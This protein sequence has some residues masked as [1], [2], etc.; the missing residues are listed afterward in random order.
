MSRAV[1]REFVCGVVLLSTALCQHA[2]VAAGQTASQ[3]ARF[4]V[5]SI[6]PILSVTG[7]QM[8]IRT[9]PGGGINATGVTP[10]FLIRFAFAIDDAL[11]VGAPAWIGSARFDVVATGPP[12]VPAETTRGMVRA[13]LR[14]RF[15]LQSRREARELPVYE[16]RRRTRQDARRGANIRPAAVACIERDARTPRPSPPATLP[17]A[18]EPVPCGLRVAFGHISGGGI[19]MEELST[20][21]TQ[22]SARPV[23]NRTALAGAFDVVLN[24]TP[25]ALRLAGAPGPDGSQADNPTPAV[26][27]T[28]TS[29]FT[30]VQEQLRLR[31][32]SSRAPVEVLV[33]DHIERPTPD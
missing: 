31:L 32:D 27:R 19:T 15:N 6:K 5:A 18:H 20:A 24:F 13:L 30:A 33:I 22:P 14:E 2:P 11:I 12:Q 8:I 29:L 9:P 25:E 21:L 3:D 17:P 10:R 4:E 23:L 1:T 16:L 28:G 26:D 7:P